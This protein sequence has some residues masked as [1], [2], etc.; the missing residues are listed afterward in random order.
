MTSSVASDQ[1]RSFSKGEM[2]PLAP[3]H[4][5]ALFWTLSAAL[6]FSRDSV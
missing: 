1:L 3:L 5:T 4:S 2:T 6:V